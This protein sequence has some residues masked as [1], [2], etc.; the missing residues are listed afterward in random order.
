MPGTYTQILLHIVFSTKHR[1]PLITDAIR[2]RLYGY[3]GGIVRAEQGALHAI[4]GVDDHVHLLVRWRADAAISDLMR[5]L[6]SRS[7]K[8]VKSELGCEGFAWQEGYAAFSVSKSQADVVRGYIAKQAEHH[9]EV[10]FR[11][12]L[13]RLLDAH[14]VDF[15]ARW[16]DE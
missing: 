15:D 14:G 11:E 9:R 7:T 2:E 16:I 10:G 6:K 12:E 4:G 3:I 8:W 5:T 13:V 1:E